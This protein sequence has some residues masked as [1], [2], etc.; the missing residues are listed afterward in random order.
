MCDG[1][2]E[3]LGVMLALPHFARVSCFEVKCGRHAGTGNAHLGVMVVLV[4][5]AVV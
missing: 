2:V 1:R 3:H 5:P 4:A